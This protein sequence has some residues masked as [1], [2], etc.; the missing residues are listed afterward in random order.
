MIKPI[1]VAIPPYY[2]NDA[3]QSSK[4]ISEFVVNLSNFVYIHP[5]YKTAYSYTNAEL[6]PFS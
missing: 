2:P 4:F 3:E 5:L 1:F 6:A